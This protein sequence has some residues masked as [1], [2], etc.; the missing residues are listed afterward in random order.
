M[1]VVVCGV[2]EYGLVGLRAHLGLYLLQECLVGNVLSFLVVVQSVQSHV[3]PCPRPLF[4]VE[5]VCYARGVGHPSPQ[6]FRPVLAVAVYWHSALEVLLAVLQY[7]FRDLAEVDVEVSSMVTGLVFLVYEGVHHPELDVFYV[8]GLEVGIVHLPHHS[9]PL[10][11][12]VGQPS[13]LLHVRRQVV[14]AAFGGVEG[15]VQHVEAA[16][17]VVAVLCFLWVKF[18]LVYLPHVVVGQLLQVA[19]DV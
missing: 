10:L 1:V 17:A 19:L 13:V 12:R 15:K 6:S 5:G 4:V 16:C 14:C 2:V 9:A 3:L 18:P 8:L 11:L 7:V